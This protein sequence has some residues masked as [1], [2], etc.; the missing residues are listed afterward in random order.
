MKSLK[1]FA[2]AILV[3][4][5]LCTS[6]GQETKV[7]SKVESATLYMNG[8]FVKRKAIVDPRSKKS[9]LLFVSIPN[10]A[11]MNSIQLSADENVKIISVKPKSVDIENHINDALLLRL[12]D[13]LIQ[14]QNAIST[15]EI[16]N[17]VNKDEEAILI[18]NQPSFS[19]KYALKP[20][21]LNDV[22][23]FNGTKLTE[24]YT[25]SQTLKKENDLLQLSKKEITK[26]YLAIQ[27]A[28]KRTE[29]QIE[30][31]IESN[32]IQAQHFEIT[33]F[34]LFASWQP[35][36]DLR[37]IDISNP[38]ELTMKANLLQNTGEDWKDINIS[39]SNGKPTAN[40]TYPIIAPWYLNFYAYTPPIYN[41]QG[42]NPNVKHV[43]GKVT[44]SDGAVIIGANVY[45]KGLNSI[46]S[47]TDI[48]GNYYLPITDG[49][50]HVIVS[51]SGYETQEQI[52][53]SENMDFNLSEGKLLDEVVKL[54]TGASGTVYGE[55]RK[56]KIL[57]DVNAL[58]IDIAYQ[59]TTFS[60]DVKELFSLKSSPT[61]I[62]IHVL[63]HEI[64]TSY[65]YYTVPKYD[66]SVFM[67]ASIHQ[68]QDYNLLDGKI[69]L[70]FEG[71]YLG[72]S[73]LNTKSAGD[74]LKIS[75]GRDQNIVV[76]RTKIKDFAKKSFISGNTTE[77]NAYAISIKNNKNLPVHVFVQDH[78][79]VSSNKS[80]EVFDFEAKSGSIH[81]DSRIVTWDLHIKPK[82]EQIVE[83]RY[84]VKRPSGKIVKL[85]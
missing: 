78:I 60:Y 22:I 31:E 14:I 83:L 34:T 81:P 36:Y 46:G 41:Q 5:M 54:S 17:K 28:N 20:T 66:K 40:E 85:E 11:D 80:I 42:Y 52:I 6:L 77:I 44:D 18:K 21:E 26:R 30:V 56:D 65:Q 71:R 2:I 8:A 1:I 75:L 73:I 57:K 70:Y 68:W 69:N 45:L 72:Q 84:S 33:Y 35:S 13:T 25:L 76:E 67:V 63:D 39:V 55:F 7:Y 37:V 10:T 12:K 53:Q 48:D 50:K 58:P 9:K 3:T 61:P 29:I 15:N 47:V 27:A 82:T 79:P 64:P 43:S 16:R 49:A 59:A 74:T 19:D 4:T 24:I 62:T 51:Y 23:N 32:I 38:I